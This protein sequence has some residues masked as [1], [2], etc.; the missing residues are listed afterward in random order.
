M[1]SLC[2][3]HGDGQSR[4]EFLLKMFGEELIE[5]FRESKKIWDPA[6]RRTPT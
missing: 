4:A 6:A 5:A 3:K 2:G 1:G